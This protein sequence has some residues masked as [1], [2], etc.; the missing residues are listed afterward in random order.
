MSSLVLLA[1]SLP[2]L[3]PIAR[4]PTPTWKELRP[5]ADTSSSSAAST[6]SLGNLICPTDISCPLCPAGQVCNQRS[7]TATQCAEYVC[8]GTTSGSSVSVGGLV[9]GVIGGVAVLTAVAIL[10]YFRFVRKKR[11]RAAQDL[12][13]GE[14]DTS[15]AGFEE[16]LRDEK[17]E[18]PKLVSAGLS[19]LATANHRLLA[20]DS[21]MRPQARY[22]RT[23]SSGSSGS[24]PRRTTPL[25]AASAASAGATGAPS[26]GGA[27]TAAPDSNYAASKRAS[28]ATTISTT[29][30]LNI[31][32]VAYIPGVTIRPSK[33]NTRLIY[34]YES[35]LIFSDFNAID[36]ALIVADR[37]A[38]AAKGTMTAIRAQ[39]RLVNV[40]PINEDDETEAE[41]THQA[42]DG[43]SDPDSDVDSDIGEIHRATSTRR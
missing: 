30:A 25:T 28:I 10:L 6:D 17:Q 2:Y 31:L 3:P 26:A 15:G 24:A 14:I 27:A 41:N 36:N 23:G 16:L 42:S 1:P 5:R 40:V 9:G 22:A 18:R 19:S 38:A 33:N 29:N 12:A 4:L 35:D 11:K 20:Y 32:P 13:L 34:S 21:F 37:N 43:E 8:V 7:R 39:P